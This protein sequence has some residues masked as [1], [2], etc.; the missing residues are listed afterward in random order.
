[1][2]PCGVAALVDTLVL[3]NGEVSGVVRP[4]SAERAGR[5]SCIGVC[6]QAGA[7]VIRGLGVGF[8]RM[9]VATGDC[10]GLGTLLQAWEIDRRLTLKS[11]HGGQGPHLRTC[12]SDGRIDAYNVVFRHDLQMPNLLVATNTAMIAHDALPHSNP[13]FS[14]ASR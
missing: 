10:A 6:L 13:N 14:Q 2:E 3:C 11:K 9:E 4:R 5:C 7:A 8:E 1:M 12:S